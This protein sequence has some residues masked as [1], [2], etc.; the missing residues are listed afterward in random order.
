MNNEDTHFNFIEYA[1]N[2]AEIFKNRHL[3]WGN[4]KAT[5][6]QYTNKQILPTQSNTCYVVGVCFQLL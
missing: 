3:I 5:A 2:L 6:Y 1:R 4:L